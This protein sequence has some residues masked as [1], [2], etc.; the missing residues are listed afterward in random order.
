MQKH[1]YLCNADR[2]GKGNVGVRPSA[3]GTPE[4]MGEEVTSPFFIK[5]NKHMKKLKFETLE[6][7]RETVGNVTISFAVRPEVKYLLTLG[8][9]KAGVSFSEFCRQLIE[10]KAEAFQDLKH[11]K[12]EKEPKTKKAEKRDPLHFKTRFELKNHLNKL[13]YNLG[14]GKISKNREIR[15]KLK[16]YIIKRLSHKEY[17]L[18]EKE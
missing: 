11:E 15:V 4:N 5:A 6:E 13:G 17:S 8:A 18:E 16:S 1:D 2:R 7:L 14:D 10:N 9:K 12:E 3:I